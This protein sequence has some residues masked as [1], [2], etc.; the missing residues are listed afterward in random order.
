MW[1][2]KKIGYITKKGE[3]KYEFFQIMTDFVLGNWQTIVHLSE[4]ETGDFEVLYSKSG[5]S[6]L[7]KLKE[8]NPYGF[9]DGNEGSDD[10]LE[11]NYLVVVDDLSMQMLAFVD[12]VEE[13]RL[14]HDSP[15]YEFVGKLV[16]S[17]SYLDYNRTLFMCESMP[18]CV[19]TLF[20]AMC[21][22]PN[23]W[24]DDEFYLYSRKTLDWAGNA[25][26][27]VDIVY[28]VRFCDVVGARRLLAKALVSDINPVR[29][30]TSAEWPV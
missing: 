9:V 15:I 4:T 3:T 7:D 23:G 10:M 20:N 17:F 8:L 29:D 1:V 24:L 2:V 12:T 5:R 22:C 28:R 18:K 13:I 19:C 26:D 21:Y 30:L 16:G 27:M 25:L 11:D 14:V 6:Y